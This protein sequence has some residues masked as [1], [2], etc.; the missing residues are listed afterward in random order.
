MANNIKGITIEIG[1]DTTKLDKAL[2][3]VN[4]NVKSTQA[5]LREVEKL[6]KL[7]PK[8]TEALAQK[9]QL[10]TKAVGETKEKLDVLKT[11]EAQV[12]EQ[13]K[14]GEVS[15]EQYRAIK[16]EIE[17][18]ELSLKKLEE[19]AGK[20]N[21][22]LEKVGEAF[23]KVGGKATGIGNKLLPVTAGVTA[24]G[25]AGVAAAME[26][27]DGYDTIITKTG[28]TGEALEELNGIADDLFT[29]MPIEMQDAGTAVGEINTRFG[30][31]GDTLKDLSKQFIE[32][33]NINDT[34]L[35]NSIGKTDK[36]MEQ[37]NIDA[38]ETGNVLGLLTKKGQETGISVDT[39]MDSLQ[40]NGATF[41]EMGLN[42]VQSTNL[43]AQFE[44]NAV[45]AA[46]AALTAG[47]IFPTTVMMF[48]MPVATF[49]KMISAGPIA[50]T[51]AAILI[52]VSFWLWLKF[53]NHCVNSFT[54]PTTFV[55]VGC[56]EPKRVV[57]RSAAA[58]FKL[59]A[60][61]FA[62]SHGSCVALNVSSTT[63][64]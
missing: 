55:M 64:P 58:N 61:T 10:L 42:L 11:A 54:F 43:L 23:G 30:A 18:T 37:Y 41:K 5:E 28:A 63:V 53:L 1:G 24:L 17:A 15:E 19:E 25:G 26:L 62:S 22:S 33:A 39:L 34:D 60:A 14:K 4:K 32:F 45:N 3:G 21:I 31:T 35:N 12:E 13:F 16:R 20:S 2:G 48:E 7:D 52:M 40:K 29:E 9:Q 36:I 46:F 44:A 57:P 8:N 27:D 51:T 38:S 6:L 59:L 47:P 56:N 49:P 50:A